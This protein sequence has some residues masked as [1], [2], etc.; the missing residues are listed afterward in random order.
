[1]D[2][3]RGRDNKNEGRKDKKET[4]LRSKS[5]KPPGSRYDPNACGHEKSTFPVTKSGVP[6][7][8]KKEHVGLGK[9]SKGGEKGR[10]VLSPQGPNINLLRG[11]KNQRDEGE[12]KKNRTSKESG[13]EKEE[14][15]Q[16]K[17]R[18]Y[19]EMS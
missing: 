6:D 3:G 5:A 10:K 18:N 9:R 16:G 1:V 19:K 2:P 11:G 8:D 7:K 15:G 17:G 13:G 14:R 12:K 4:R